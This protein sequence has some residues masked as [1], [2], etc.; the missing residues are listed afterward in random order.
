MRLFEQLSKQEC[1]TMLK[2]AQKEMKN[3]YM[4]NDLNTTFIEESGFRPQKNMSL[5]LFKDD[6]S[7][8]LL[9]SC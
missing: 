3:M 4:W 8:K 2:I 1:S 6:F 9:S 5:S 7:S